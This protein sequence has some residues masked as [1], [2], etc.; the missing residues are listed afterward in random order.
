MQP[1]TRHEPFAEP[2][3][4]RGADTE[5]RMQEMNRST[6][7]AVAQAGDS[8]PLSGPELPAE[9][10]APDTSGEAPTRAKE[11][12]AVS[13]VADLK[14]V[15]SIEA[16]L[17]YAY[18]RTG[19]F[20]IPR[21]V[22]DALTVDESLIKDLRETIVELA[23][24]DPLMKVPIRI[25]AAVDRA[26]GSLKFRRRCTSAVALI[27][28]AHSGLRSVPGLDSALL[29]P[30]NGDPDLLL[31]AVA[32]SIEAGAATDL[33]ESERRVLRANA[34]AGL[35]LY[36]AI[37]RQWSEGRLAQ[38]L[39]ATLWVEEYRATKL[40]KRE[41]L[42]VL[43]IEASPAA[44]GTVGQTWRNQLEEERSRVARHQELQQ[45]AEAERDRAATL[46]LEAEGRVDRLRAEL[47]DRRVEIDQLSAEVAQ[48]QQARRVQSSHAVDD[49]ENLRTRVIRTIDRQLSLLEDGLHALRSESTAVTE[50]Y[51]ERV[52]E[53]LVKEVDRLRDQNNSVRESG[54]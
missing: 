6:Q 39:D 50:E 42:N 49:Y 35:S 48:E 38:A 11:E 25:L 14:D 1:S 22:R 46:Q 19:R 3:S 51:L 23:A 16:L 30:D 8:A 33:K 52:I 7:A 54:A 32:R 27:F 26:K 21:A 12:Q 2:R 20:S 4:Q 24:R 47:N 36:F 17:L 34:V 10:F 53:S 9:G 15:R 31:S 41:S 44:L 37:Q 13:K 28:L 5:K 45:A 29:Y 43:L 40:N 18:G